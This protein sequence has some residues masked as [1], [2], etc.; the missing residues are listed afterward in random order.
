MKPS[1]SPYVSHSR[2]V[3]PGSILDVSPTHLNFIITKWTLSMSLACPA[4]TRR[5]LRHVGASLIGRDV[6]D[7][8]THSIIGTWFKWRMQGIKAELLHYQETKK[9]GHFK[10]GDVSVSNMCRTLILLGHSRTHV[11]YSFFVSIIENKNLN[12][13]H[14]SNTIFGNMSDI[15][16]VSITKA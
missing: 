1:L 14:G 16:Y 11:Q 9:H 4:Q 2:Y 6:R 15:S 7:Y 3:C 8:A 12:S 13:I 10:E 5:P